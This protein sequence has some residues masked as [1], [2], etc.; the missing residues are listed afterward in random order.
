[1]C[2]SIACT[3]LQGAAGDGLM[4]EHRASGLPHKALRRAP[5]PRVAANPARLPPGQER[6]VCAAVV[7]QRPFV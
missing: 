7:R 5:D 3:V 4:A 1:M 6:P 2:G